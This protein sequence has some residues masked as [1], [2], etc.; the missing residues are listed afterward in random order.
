[1]VRADQGQRQN[2]RQVDAELEQGA[3]KR[4]ARR[5]FSSPHCSRPAVLTPCFSSPFVY[6]TKSAQVSAIVAAACAG[7]TCL[8]VVPLLFWRI[9]ARIKRDED[10]A[11]EKAAQEKEDARVK[12]EQEMEQAAT[13]SEKVPEKLP[14]E[15]SAI[16][17]DSDTPAPVK[18]I[19][20]Y[21][22]YFY[23]ACCKIKCA[24]RP[25]RFSHFLFLWRSICVLTHT[26]T[27]RCR[28]ITMHGTEVDIFDC[29]EDDPSAIQRRASSFKHGAHIAS[30][31]SLRFTNT[32]RSS[33]RRLKVRNWDD[34]KDGPNANLSPDVA[35]H[36]VAT[37]VFSY[38]QVFSAICVI[39]AHGAGEVGY[40]A[41]PLGAIW[42]VVT[43]GNIKS[44]V[45]SRP[46]N[47]TP[48]Y[49]H[50]SP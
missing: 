33:I 40:M 13:T 20:W 32:R 26:C 34:P 22:R 8:F 9:N 7:A 45:S 41:G 36:S 24:P 18:P 11:E 48:G 29:V 12:K 39:F 2:A 30:Q 4:R 14:T 37:V 6:Q 47:V 3:S 35:W 31:L 19:A 5:T 27:G 28:Y 23:S 38:L 25:T 10:K 49:R 43:T 1:M 16:E 42:Q 21:K 15:I 46:G 50:H 17:V 44:K